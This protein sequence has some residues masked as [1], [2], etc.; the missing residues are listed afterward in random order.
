M[1]RATAI[2]QI[3][4]E[5][6]SE[7]LWW[8]WHKHYGWVVL[9]R[10]LPNLTFYRCDIWETF[11]EQKENWNP[12]LYVSAENYLKT[13][14]RD[15]LEIVIADLQDT[16]KLL[17]DLREKKYRRTRLERYQ[18][19]YGKHQD[20]LKTVGKISVGIR[21][22]YSV[23]RTSICWNCSNPVDNSE[24]YECQLC[25]WIICSYCGTCGCQKN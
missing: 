21:D 17:F 9:D 8:G 22:A 13:V 18:S 6:T 11:S 12:P 4:S 5:I 10:T 14:D 24:D 23:H 1:N 15:M 2:D 25:E 19:I 3:V 20:Y 16:S 7:E